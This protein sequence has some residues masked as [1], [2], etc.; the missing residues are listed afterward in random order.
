M[1]FHRLGRFSSYT[2]RRA[3]EL[4]GAWPHIG[5]RTPT[6][7]ARRHKESRTRGEKGATLP[8]SLAAQVG[9]GLANQA[10]GFAVARLSVPRLGLSLDTLSTPSIA[11]RHHIREIR[12]FWSWEPGLV[13]PIPLFPP[14]LSSPG[15]RDESRLDSRSVSHYHTTIPR[16]YFGGPAQTPNNTTEPPSHRTGR[17][18]SPTKYPDDRLRAELSCLTHRSL[19]RSEMG[20]EG[21]RAQRPR[22]CGLGAVQALFSKSCCA[23]EKCTTRTRPVVPPCPPDDRCCASAASLLGGT[24]RG[25]LLAS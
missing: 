4:P 3:R 24:R 7:A 14:S 9:V 21:T 6:M 15:S 20:R 12:S 5:R 1:Y 2:F 19:G 17:D 23:R 10:R 22:G 25:S 11:D 8:T 18:G 13:H 16:G